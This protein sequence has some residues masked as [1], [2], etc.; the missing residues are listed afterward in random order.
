SAVFV[1]AVLIVS[2]MTFVVWLLLGPAENRFAIG[3]L[4]A[5][6]VM[7]IACPCALGLATPMAILVGTGRGARAGVLF[8]DATALE[9]LAQ[10]NMLV[11]D[12]T[13]TITGGKPTV[14]TIEPAAG[15][16][17][18]EV[19]RLVASVEQASEHPLAAAVVAAARERGLTLT[20]PDEF[21]AKPGRGVTGAVGGR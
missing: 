7:I 2:V 8:R 15:L 4:H 1:P 10:A 16:T 11:L 3:M 5:V 20:R 6:A 13:G 18:Q 9:Q 12:K 21:Q 14:A 19:L 17:E